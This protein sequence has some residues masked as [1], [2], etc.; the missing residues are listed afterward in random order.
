MG[1][2]SSSLFVTDKGFLYGNEIIES[3]GFKLGLPPCVILGKF[4]ELEI[5]TSKQRSSVG[6]I[7]Y[8]ESQE[9]YEITT[10]SGSSFL[11]D[12]DQFHCIYD[13]ETAQTKKKRMSD[14]ER[15]DLLLSPTL[16]LDYEGE[17]CFSEIEL[18]LAGVISSRADILKTKAKIIFDTEELIEFLQELSLYEQLSGTTLKDLIGPYKKE[19]KAGFVHISWKLSN[20]EFSSFSNVFSKYSMIFSKKTRCSPLCDLIHVLWGFIQFSKEEVD[21]HT[22]IS[23]PDE[24][25]KLWV[26]L[27]K[28]ILL[29]YGIKLLNDKERYYVTGE[30]WEIFRYFLQKKE[31]LN[32]DEQEK[33]EEDLYNKMSGYYSNRHRMWADPIREISKTEQEHQPISFGLLSPY[34]KSNELFQS[35]YI[36]NGVFVFSAE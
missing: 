16:T 19:K 9:L 2:S 24:D 29:G 34:S 35:Q 26:N 10:A 30:D 17:S 3:I 4:N 32:P 1:L 27:I 14:L 18:W 5:E 11:C 22:F 15:G 12:K 33:F 7:F 13:K 20:K 36:V 8:G 28:T 31:F 25:K 6:K 21:D 23:F